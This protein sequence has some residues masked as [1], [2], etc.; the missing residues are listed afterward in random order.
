MVTSCPKLGAG[1]QNVLSVNLGVQYLGNLQFWSVVM[2]PVMVTIFVWWFGWFAILQDWMLRFACVR[3]F[4][5]KFKVLKQVY[6][7]S[8][9]YPIYPTDPITNMATCEIG[10]SKEG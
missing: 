7:A 10:G 4:A 6:K 3:W 1:N 5:T 9:S 2:S 8:I